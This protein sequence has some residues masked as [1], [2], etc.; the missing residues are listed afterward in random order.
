[1]LGDA[2]DDYNDSYDEATHTMFVLPE[3]GKKCHEGA[4]SAGYLR[5]ESECRRMTVEIEKRFNKPG[6]GGTVYFMGRRHSPDRP[7]GCYMWRNYDVWWNTYENGLTSPDARSICKM[8]W[9]K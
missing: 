3:W 4:R 2:N 1:M 8:V 5:T 6:D 9:S 7:Y